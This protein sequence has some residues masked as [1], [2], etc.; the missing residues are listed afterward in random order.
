MLTYSRGIEV[1]LGITLRP[2]GG[3][4]NVIDAAHAAEDA[5]FQSVYV[6][7]GHFGS[8]D[9]FAN[10]FAVA[11]AISSRVRAAWVGVIPAIGLDHPLRL[12]EH[13]N[14]LDLLTRGRS[15]MVLSDA[16]EPRQYAAFGLPV[17]RNG[18]FDDLLQRLDDAWSW[19]Y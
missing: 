16:F 5:G 14:M 2:D 17:P 12:V 9:G 10:P 19:D 18:L 15:L 4:T 8:A 1:R 3:L 7:E 6:A 11:A 13:A